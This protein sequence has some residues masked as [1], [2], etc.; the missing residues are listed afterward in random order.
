MDDH[1]ITSYDHLAAWVEQFIDSCSP[2]HLN[3][4]DEQRDKKLV[5]VQYRPGDAFA[6]PF[7]D[8]TVGYGRILLDIFRLRRTGLFQSV[9]HCGLGGPVLGS[10]LLLVIYRYAG[11]TI[12][13]DEIPQLPALGTLLT[14]H[15]DI[16]RGRFE[17]VGNIPVSESELDFPEGVIAWHSGDG[18]TEYHFQK[19][20]MTVALP[21]TREEYDQIPKIG[22]SFGLVPRRIWDAIHGDPEALRCIV[23]DLRTSGQRPEILRRCNLNG[24]MSYADMVTAKGGVTLNE[25]IRATKVESVR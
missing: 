4:I 21:M 10:G 9:P 19:G 20:G 17:I 2:D 22:C 3:R 11:Q 14:M 7:D 15:D 24:T 16:Y 18:S 1:G 25:F 5:R 6:I 12:A 13:L 8:D 23:D